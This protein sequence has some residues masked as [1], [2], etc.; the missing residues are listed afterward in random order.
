MIFGESSQTFARCDYGDDVNF[1]DSPLFQ[2]TNQASNRL[3]RSHN[4][5]Q[6]IRHITLTLPGQPIIIL[7]RNAILL[8]HTNMMHTSLRHELQHGID[9]TITAPHNR[10]ERY[11]FHERFP[12]TIHV[13]RSV[14]YSQRYGTRR[15]RFRSFVS[16]VERDFAQYRSEVRAFRGGRAEERDFV[17]QDGMGGYCDVGA[18]VSGAGGA[19]DVIWGWGGVVVGCCGIGCFGAVCWCCHCCVLCHCEMGWW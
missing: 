1:G 6:Y 4:R 9:H 10:H 3:C 11:P 16:E 15:E 8:I 18:V 7:H 13:F 19:R 2:Y 5:I 17:L 12:S 14:R